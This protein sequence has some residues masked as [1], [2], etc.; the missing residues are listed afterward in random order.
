MAAGLISRKVTEE[1]DIS[2]EKRDFCTV[3][4]MEGLRESM[5]PYNCP[6]Q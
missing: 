6:S 2:K 3:E 5:R 1:V 4:R